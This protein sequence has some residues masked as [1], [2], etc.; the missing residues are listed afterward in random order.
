MVEYLLL[1]SPSNIPGLDVCQLKHFQNDY[2][3]LPVSTKVNILR[4]LCDDITEV[5]TF[6]SEINR[7]M[8]ETDRSRDL[9]HSAK[10]DR[11]TKRKAALGVANIS[12]STEDDA[13]EPVDGNSDECCLCRM[14]GELICC[15]GCPAAFHS[16]CAGIVT[17][18]L[19]EGKWYCLECT[20]EK[21][22][23]WMKMRN[24]IR[25]AE[26]LGTDPYGRAYYRSCGYLLV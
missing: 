19:P 6:R 13:V 5:E 7:R 21:D 20:M 12:C 24:S 9:A 22:K 1:H 3:K 17:R 23:P 15:D 10:F 4:H 14:D 26:L 8:L 18:L 2:Y 11:S 16:R 25:G